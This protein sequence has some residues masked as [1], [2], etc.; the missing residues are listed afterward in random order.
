MGVGILP[1]NLLNN[2][3]QYLSLGAASSGLF[4]CYLL[5]VAC[6]GRQL[7]CRKY[8]E[9]KKQAITCLADVLHIYGCI[10]NISI[11]AVGMCVPECCWRVMSVS[12]N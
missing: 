5:S 1:R 12:G 7:N 10:Y 2:W 11:S 9:L 3:R 8:L 4:I 6:S